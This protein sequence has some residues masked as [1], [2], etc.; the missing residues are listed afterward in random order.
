MDE[1]IQWQG[2]ERLGDVPRQ[3]AGRQRP[4]GV[5]KDPNGVFT[6]VDG[7]I[8]ASGETF[9]VISTTKE[10]ENYRLRLEVK[11]GEKRWP[12]RAD[13]KRD[14]GILYH[15]FGDYGGHG[16]A[17]TRSHECQIQEGDFGDYWSLQAMGT[18]TL[19]PDFTTFA[20]EGT[21][22]RAGGAR[23]VRSADHEKP[24]GE[25]NTVEVICSGDTG[26]PHRQRPG[27]QP[28]DQFAQAGGGRCDAAHEG[29]DPASVRKAR[30]F[31]IATS[32]SAPSRRR[33]EVGAEGPAC[34]PTSRRS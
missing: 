33:D 34:S 32:S 26:D 28:L 31:S 8:R 14:A 4:I 29:P 11:W 13:K 18:F 10:F 15:A 21:V 1:T 9:G 3:A 30:R 2:P 27:R 20:P 16:S 24:R 23:V 7:A 6:V 25:W 5:N 22:W 12:P 19:T 17:W